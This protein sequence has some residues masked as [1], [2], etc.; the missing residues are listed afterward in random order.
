MLDYQNNIE[1]FNKKNARI[2]AVSSDSREK[3]LGFASDLNLTFKVGYGLNAKETSEIT[4]A[5]YND[6]GK[7]L[8]ATGFLIKPLGTIKIVLYSPGT[9]ERLQAK[10]AFAA[11]I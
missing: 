10:D 7:Y 4:G 8:Y 1:E 3:A 9:T 11:I 2:I 5:Y 6:K